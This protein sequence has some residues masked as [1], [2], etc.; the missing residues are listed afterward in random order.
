M[1]HGTMYH[2]TRIYIYVYIHIRLR[3][4]IEAAAKSSQHSVIVCVAAPRC[5]MG[6]ERTPHVHTPTFVGSL[7]AFYMRVHCVR[8]QTDS[9][10]TRACIRACAHVHPRGLLRKRLLR[11]S[12]SESQFLIAFFLTPKSFQTNKKLSRMVPHRPIFCS[13]KKGNLIFARSA[14]KI[15]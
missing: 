11:N 3:E 5:G 8:V 14:K 10:C 12:E 15:F 4:E 9:T 7:R 1:H 13:R 2:G 6:R